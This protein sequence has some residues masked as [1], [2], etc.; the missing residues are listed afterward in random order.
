MSDV[1]RTSE[2]QQP[3]T[4]APLS[5]RGLFRLSALAVGGA[6]AAPA[7]LERSASADTAPAGSAPTAA[8]APRSAYERSADAAADR[9][10]A[11]ISRPRIPCRDFP[12]GRYG[13]VADGA[14][15]N[16]A[17][18]AAAIRDASAHGGGRVVVPAG[19]YA[20]GPIHLLSHVELH[21]EAGSTLLFSTDPNAYLPVVYT[22][23][24]GIELMNYSP[25]VYALDQHDI[26]ITGAGVLDGQASTANW[27]GW[28]SLE[29]ADFALLSAQADAGVPVEQ[30]VY[31]AGFHMPPAFV[32][33]YRCERVLLQGV[34]FR[35][36]PFWHLHP[37]LCKSV[38]VEGVTVNSSGPNTDG[39]DPEC[40]DGVLIDRVTFNAGDDC[41]A[42]KSGRNTDGRRVNVPSRN[43]VIQNSSFANGHGAVTV[44]SEMTGGV[45]DVYARDLSL[46]SAGLQSGHRLKT[47]SVRGGYIRNT[48]VYRVAASAVGGPVL[49]IDFNYGEGN[50]GTY[51]PLVT[52]VNLAKWTVAT[53][54][55]GWDAIGYSTDPIGTV[56]LSDVTITAMTGTNVAQYV[57]DF[58]L[59]EVTVAGVPVTSAAAS[60]VTS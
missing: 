31:G 20:T 10:I 52:D 18:F 2:I 50:T 9:V 53:C 14:T 1:F 12:V 34:T 26:A 38:T 32:E 45:R 54:V 49:L 48:N 7:L 44:G 16:T 28:K 41:I 57:S 29:N 33:P 59:S 13:A 4:P 42:I 47:N 36:S 46:T 60:A 11:S 21:L 37:T 3:A 5:R 27:W 40:C 39:C 17:A 51:P 23:W 25:L 56:K 35:N 15:D 55:Q 58:E 8:P 6:L 24:Q 43:I 30:R 22:R 19:N